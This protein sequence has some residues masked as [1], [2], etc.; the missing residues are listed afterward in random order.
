VKPSRAMY[1]HHHRRL[2]R[3]LPVVVTTIGL[4]LATAAANAACGPRIGSQL[5]FSAQMPFLAQSAGN[6]QPDPN[7]PIVGLWHVI[8]TSGGELFLETLD[9]WHS[10]GTE[11]EAANALPTEGNICFGVWKKTGPRSVRLFHIGWNFDGSGTPIGTFTIEE[12]NKVAR[13]G[14]TYQGTF[15]FKVYDLDGNLVFETTGTQLANRITVN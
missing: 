1:G 10:D 4:L 3:H 11:F 2:L 9:Q 14:A 13:G 12:S 7:S 6:S 8:Y 5:A 15:D